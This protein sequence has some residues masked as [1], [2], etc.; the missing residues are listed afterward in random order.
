MTNDLQASA[1]PSERPRWYRRPVRITRDGVLFA[2]G[3][4]IVLH[5]LLIESTVRPEFLVLATTF[6]GAVPFLQKGDKE[7]D[8]RTN[9]DS[10]G[11]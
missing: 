8:R 7:R 9:G 2:V 5:E 4:A 3:I 1:A 10:G 6:V 11:S